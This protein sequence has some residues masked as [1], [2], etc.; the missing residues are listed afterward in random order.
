MSQSGSYVSLKDCGGV[1]EA[2][3]IGECAFCPFPRHEWNT[4]LDMR[5]ETS[6]FGR[7]GKAKKRWSKPG[8][9]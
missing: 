8:G 4:D 1:K 7:E 9:G 5:P 6:C 2:S 3:I